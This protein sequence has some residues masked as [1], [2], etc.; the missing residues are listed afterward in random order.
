[1]GLNTLLPSNLP[2]A[3]LRSGSRFSSAVARHIAKNDQ[4]FVMNHQDRTEVG[5]HEV[6]VCVCVV[7]CVL[8]CCVLCVVVDVVC[9]SASCR[10]SVKC[11][12]Q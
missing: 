6:C 2:D 5:R 11:Q 9:V 12:S 3:S 8:L 4:Q 1:M 7:W 10:V